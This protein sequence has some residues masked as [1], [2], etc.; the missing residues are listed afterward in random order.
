MSLSVAVFVTVNNVSQIGFS[1]TNDYVPLLKTP[2]S[3]NYPPPTGAFGRREIAA[4]VADCTGTNNGKSD[5]VTV[6]GFACFFLLQ[7]TGHS[8]GSSYIVA[9][10]ITSCPGHGNPGP[11][12]GTG[13]G[14]G[15]Y[16]IQLYRDYSSP[17]S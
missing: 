7:P 6:L 16:V 5:P 8:G 4:P 9:E 2:S 1:F 15:P 17:D 10:H 11:G 12:P 3:Y 13:G 14:P